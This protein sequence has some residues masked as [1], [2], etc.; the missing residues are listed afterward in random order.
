MPEMFQFHTGY[1]AHLHPEPSINFQMN[2]WINYLGGS[3]LEDMQN[4]APLLSDFRSYRREFLALAKKA[5]SEGRSL[6]A[7]YYLRSAEFFMRR[8]DPEKIPTQQSFLRLIRENY[9]IKEGDRYLIPYTDGS[10]SGFLPAYHFSHAKPKDTIVIHGGFDSYIE[11]FFPVIFFIHAA[12]YAVICFEGPGQGAALQESDL[13]LT[14]EWHKP[15]K[16]VLDYFKLEDVS[17]LGISMGAC[18]ALRAA[19]FEPR[20]KRVIAY[21]VFFD[22]MDTTLEKLKPVG[23]FLK[24]LLNSGASS[25]FN[26]LLK[27]IMAKSPLF[28]WAMHQSMVLLGVSTSYEVFRLSKQYTTRDIAPLIRQ[29]VLLM[30]GSEDQFI[31]LRHF[32]QQG[33]ALKNVR[34]LTARLFTREQQAQSHCQMGNLSLAI[35]TITNWIDYMRQ[36]NP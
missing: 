10:V 22:W 7:A 27:G 12:G 13:L 33:E 8:D 17:L 11:E 36:G 35:N 3:A 28:D 4:I 6:H 19:A 5:L 2:R 16:A 29:D 9:A 1:Y 34:S 31:P 15:V 26:I 18:L 23:S 21:D 24:L 25:L 32:Y 30:A 20:I 14:H